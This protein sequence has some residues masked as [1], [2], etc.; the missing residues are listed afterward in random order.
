MNTALSHVIRLDP[1]DNVL[2]ARVEVPQGTHI[3]EIGAQ[4]LQAVAMGHKIA[5]RALRAGEAIL[6]YNT[7][8]GYAASDI[9]AGSWVHSHNMRFDAVE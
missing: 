2:I 9:P 3:A 5:A 1:A 7:T 6:K 8:I 4:T